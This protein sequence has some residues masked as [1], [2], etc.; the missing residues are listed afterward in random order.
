M[1]VF[2]DSSGLAKRYV[3]K[4]GVIKLKISSQRPAKPQSA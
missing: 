4:E 1:K 3:R 2:F